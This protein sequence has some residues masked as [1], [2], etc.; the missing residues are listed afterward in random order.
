MTT[1]MTGEL[2]FKPVSELSA[3]LEKKEITSVEL[4]QAFIDRTR[5][6]DDKVKA[7]LHFDAEDALAQ[8]RASDER[9]SEGKT[10]GPLDGIPVGIKDILAVKGQPL[11]C[12]SRILEDFI[13]PYD[14]TG[15]AKLRAAGAILWGRL[16]MDE[17]AMG[18]STENSAFKQ[19][20][21]P[22][23]LECVPGGSSGG[24]AA[25]VAAAQAPVTLGTDT[26]GSIRQPAAFAGIVGLK[27]TYGLVSRYG[28]VAFASSLDQ[29]GPMGQSV[30]DVAMLLQAIAGHD[31]LDSTSCKVELP[32]YT[33]AA[34]DGNIPKKI[35]VPKE[36]FGEG[37][38][39]EVRAAV[40]RAIMFYKDQGS[41]IVDVSLPMMEYAIPV[42]YIIAAAEA[43][44]NLARYDG[45][46]YTKRSERAKDAVDL[47]FK[48]RG[49]GFGEEVKRRI[50][51]GTYVLSS[52]YYDAYYL[53]AQK[54]RSLIRADFMK[55][56]E[57][58]DVLLTPTTPTPAFEKG[59][60]VSNPLT[61][62][63]NDIY[64]SSVNL[65]GLPGISVP[66]GF[67]K[68]GLPMGLQLI[69]K[70]FDEATLLGAANQ[71]EKAHDFSGKHP[72][73]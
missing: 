63:L 69:G 62:Y 50:A 1:A 29:L 42:Y 35:G 19:T 54:V 22:W 59:E 71:Y 15:I 60:R 13:S 57:E 2:I 24:S 36:Y 53:R 61:M 40:E 47:Y 3:L 6:V 68:S 17:F 9:R 30:E 55:A 37:L 67:A 12:A 31:P 73:L 8:A 39:D 23:N 26:G 28:L 21:N 72:Q 25:A 65:A 64:T 14:A 27:P 38:D 41:E 20:A 44:S 11:T 48:S 4:M 16:N 32:D 56:F 7:F 49:E 58:V 45:V 52:G 33:K 51:L 18:S 70:P 43:S 5:A 10:L 46:R 34:R 66:C